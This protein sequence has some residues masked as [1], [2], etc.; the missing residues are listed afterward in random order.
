MAKR[1]PFKKMF[2]LTRFILV[3]FF[4]IMNGLLYKLSAQDTRHNPEMQADLRLFDRSGQLIELQKEETNL[5]SVF[6]QNSI[7]DTLPVVNDSLITDK[8]DSLDI[9]SA[10]KDTLILPEFRT[11]PNNAFFVGE[12][13]LFDVSYGLIKAGSATMSIPDT[14]YEHGRPCYHVVTTARSATF[15]DAFFKVRDRVE[16]IIDMQGLFPWRFEKHL[17]EGT[18]KSDRY[19]HYDQIN[20]KVYY[21]K[22][23]L[24]VAPYIQGVLSSFYYIRTQDLEVGKHLDVENYGDGKLYPLRILV[25]KKQRIKVPA[26]KFNCIV[27]E[28]VLRSEGIFSQKGKLT[29]WLTDDEYKIPVLMKSEVFIGSISVKLKQIRHQRGR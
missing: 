11:L 16:S 7:E 22:D 12:D 9:L 18:Y 27:V 5:D 28:P 19:V 24:D 25:H 29:I 8:I 3:L 4:L 23:T 1:S 10:E 13:L 20:N 2:L 6:S 17:R 21:K 15:F 26:G 14:V